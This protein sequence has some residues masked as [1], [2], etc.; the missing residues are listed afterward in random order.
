MNDI[1]DHKDIRRLRLFRNMLSANFDALMASTRILEINAGT[2]LIKQGAPAE[3]LHIVADGS[4]ELYSG[5]EGN[6]C[7][8]AVVRPIGT[9]I[10]AAVVKDAPYLMSAR[11]LEKSRLI[12]VPASDLRA[13]FRQD[14]DFAVSVVTELA[15]CYRSVVRHAKNLK[16]RTSRERIA[17]YFLRQSQLHDWRESFT[18]A[19]EKRLIASYLGMTPENFSRAVKSLEAEGLIV[20]GDTVTIQNRAGLEDIC[21]FDPLI[22]END[23]SF[24]GV[25]VFSKPCA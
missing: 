11:A 25:G 15:D 2:E 12:L 4:V 14:P 22:D 17:S 6:R 8:M 16:L 23:E 24:S 1:T 5:W 21:R 20:Q 18:L 9:F 19:V 10:L 7:T 13:V 3:Y